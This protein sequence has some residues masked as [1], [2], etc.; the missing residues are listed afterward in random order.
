[1]SLALT[2][3]VGCVYSTIE[4]GIREWIGFI[5]EELDERFTEETMGVLS[6]FAI[7]DFSSGTGKD[8]WSRYM[9]AS[10]TEE[11]RATTDYTE[12]GKAQLKLL[13]DFYATSKAIAKD[14][15]TLASQD[16]VCAPFELDGGVTKVSA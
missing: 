16:K 6:G 7:F 10:R 15:E 4:S 9:T 3:C 8:F 14:V 5:I 13:T 1:M 12:H 2:D 11:G